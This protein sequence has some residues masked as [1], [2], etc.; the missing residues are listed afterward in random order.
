MKK[1]GI[2]CLLL[3]VCILMSVPVQA[4]YQKERDPIQDGSHSLNAA[5]P[6]A[7]SEQY[8]ETAKAVVAYELNTDTLLY[9]C[10]EA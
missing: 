3:V 9:T 6:L 4:A 5:V 7:G 10:L 8:L 1:T 2:L